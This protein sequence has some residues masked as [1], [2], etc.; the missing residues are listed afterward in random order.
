MVLDTRKYRAILLRQNELAYSKVSSLQ[1][2][3]AYSKSWY[4][5]FL[6]DKFM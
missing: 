2:E 4:N 3:L 1:Y 6:F 5:S